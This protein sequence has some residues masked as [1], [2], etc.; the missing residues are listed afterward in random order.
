MKLMTGI[1]SLLF[2]FKTLHALD[3]GL[4]LLLRD[5]VSDTHFAH[6]L[7]PSMVSI[8]FSTQDSASFQAR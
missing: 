7:L 8:C 3:D 4:D 1:A 5:V 2:I 6:F